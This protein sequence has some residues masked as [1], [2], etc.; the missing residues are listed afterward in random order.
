VSKT[1]AATLL[2]IQF[3]LLIFFILYFFR[4]PSYDKIFLQLKL[5]VKKI[6]SSISGKI[7]IDN[8]V[9]IVSLQFICD[10]F[11]VAS[12]CNSSN[13]FQ[14]LRNPENFFAF[15]LCDHHF[16]QWFPLVVNIHQKKIQTRESSKFWTIASACWTLVFLSGC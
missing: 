4:W 12:F 6:I 2:L 13:F 14:N 3:L 7:F 11:K 15:A 1:I 8:F 16:L 10:R 9:I 5:I